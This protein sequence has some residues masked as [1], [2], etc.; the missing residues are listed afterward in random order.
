MFVIILMPMDLCS[1]S[2]P[3]ITTNSFFNDIKRANLSSAQ[4]WLVDN[5]STLVFNNETNKKVIIKVFSMMKWKI[6]STNING[7]NAIVKVKVTTPDMREITTEVLTKVMTKVA[8]MSKSGKDI[9]ESD[10]EKM[11]GEY[12][13]QMLSD[14]KVHMTT[15]E[16]DINLIKKNSKWLIKGNEEFKNIT[17]GNVLKLN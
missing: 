13:N 12:F 6:M 17:R 4:L 14:K 2:S 11:A 5:D 10:S 16:I 7:N 8:Y 15:S 9:E 1:S 3:N